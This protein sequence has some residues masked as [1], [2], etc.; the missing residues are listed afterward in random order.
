MAILTPIGRAILVFFCTLFELS[1]LTRKR[2]SSLN[3]TSCSS[4][5]Y[6]ELTDVNQMLCWLTGLL[7]RKTQQRISRPL[8]RLEVSRDN[9]S[10]TFC[11]KAEHCEQNSNFRNEVTPL[12]SFRFF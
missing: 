7:L 8:G 5:N 6:R 12:V 10:N 9:S 11:L 4:H 2:T 1:Q 3:F